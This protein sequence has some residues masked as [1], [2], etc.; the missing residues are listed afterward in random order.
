MDAA[1]H[2]QSHL[3]RPHS[4]AL[5]PGPAASISPETTAQPTA[6]DSGWRGRRATQGPRWRWLA[7][8]MLAAGPPLAGRC[9]SDRLV[10]QTADYLRWSARGPL[11]KQHAARRYP[12]IAAAELLDQDEPRRDPLKLMVL[13]DCPR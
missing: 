3:I 5:E 11:H 8:Q 12:L 2:L 10:R 9:Q 1:S 7:A 6:T 13:A 4:P